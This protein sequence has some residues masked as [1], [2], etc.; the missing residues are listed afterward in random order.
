M[1]SEPRLRLYQYEQSPYCIPVRLM[2]QHSAL[3]HEIK[4]LPYCDPSEVIRL[5]GAN[6]YHVPIVEDIL[7]KQV[8]WE[9]PSQGVAEYVNL[10][11][12]QNLFPPK[13]A[14]LNRVVTQYIENE[15]EEAGF[16]VCDA[17]Y[18]KW[19]KSDLERGLM[20]R[21]K[22]RKFGV[23]CL[24]EW[25]RDVD[26]WTTKFFKLLRPFEQMLSEHVFL[27]GD[28]PVYADYAL[29]GVLGNFLYPGTEPLPGESP[30]LKSWYN[31]MI[32]GEIPQ[33]L[34]ATQTAAQ[35]QFSKQSEHYAKGHILEDVEDVKAAIVDL[36]LKPGRKALDV[37]TG[38]GYTALYLASL[39]LDVTAC[40]I[41]QP[42]LD[43]TAALAKERNLKVTLQLHPAEQLPYPD[44]SFDL[45]ISRVAPHHFSSPEAFVR[46]SARILKMYGYLVII[47]PAALD[48]HPE[49]SAWMNEVEKNRDPSHVRMIMPREWVKW[50]TA[51]GL[52]IVKKELYSFKMP[53]LNW[54]FETANTPVENRK[55]VLE[56]VARAPASA[57]E[58]FKIG[59]ENGKIVWYWRRLTL[60][61]GK[62]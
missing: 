62:L 23:G 27:L 55:R 2:L 39:G 35:E 36:K 3:P 49:T 10:L 1:P 6:Y 14:G 43:Q 8:V 41:A 25:L 61:A 58:L 26:K 20:R 12:Q 56:L 32:K 18:D 44:D 19:I 60:V 59:T 51:Y 50:C 16:R 34:D 38:A 24:E 42:M 4:N 53:D 11:T 46:E 15:C 57:R 33:P 21:H 17:F 7:A 13:M 48:D 37:A 30:Q 22:E 40:D 31:R 47:D 29:A 45:V 28:R 54:Y 5:T 52:R 9:T